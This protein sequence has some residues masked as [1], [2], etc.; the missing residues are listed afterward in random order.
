MGPGWV[1]GPWIAPEE[2]LE[3]RAR[4][5]EQEL[6]ATRDELEQMKQQDSSEPTE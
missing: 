3:E 2:T 5:L 4:W 1:P 6:K